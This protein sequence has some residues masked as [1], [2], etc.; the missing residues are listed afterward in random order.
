MKHETGRSLVDVFRAYERLRGR[1]DDRRWAE[2]A[3]WNLMERHHVGVD[4]VGDALGRELTLLRDMLT[5]DECGDDVVRDTD[6][7]VSDRPI[8]DLLGMPESWAEETAKSWRDDGIDRFDYE[9]PMAMRDVVVYGFGLSCGLA[10]MFWIALAFA[11]RDWGMPGMADRVF[12]PSPV[13]IDVDD[14]AQAGKVVGLIAWPMPLIPWL[15][16]MLVLLVGRTYRRVLAGRSFVM[17]VASCAVL[18]VI[19]IA[20]MVSVMMMAANGPYVHTAW[21]FAFAGLYGLAAYGIGRL[22]RERDDDDADVGPMADDL[23]MNDDEWLERV[24]SLLRV[25]NDMS[26]D[27]VRRIC[28]EAET[29]AKHSGSTLVA[30]FGAPGEYAHRFAPT[31]KNRRREFWYWVFAV[32]LALSN[33][34]WIIVTGGTVTWR[35]VGQL[36]CFDIAMILAWRGWKMNRNS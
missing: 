9:Q 17:A 16:T 20:L 4:A 22:W 30:E 6:G 24:A 13:L 33:I 15:L 35:L 29:H 25:R 28:G 11:V 8:R 31:G 3:A 23:L 32:L 34:A 1:R 27:D 14:V 26:D 2:R 5:A 36:I 7:T 12:L 18:A 10:L 21:M 19:G